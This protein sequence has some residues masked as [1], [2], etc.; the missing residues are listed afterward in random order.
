MLAQVNQTALEFSSLSEMHQ[1]SF[2]NLF[3][4]DISEI[5]MNKIENMVGN[6]SSSQ[7]SFSA[8]FTSECSY[9]C[10][11]AYMGKSLN[12]IMVVLYVLCFLFLL[13]FRSFEE[14]FGMEFR[15]TRFLMYP[16]FFK[17]C[18]LCLRIVHYN[19]CPWVA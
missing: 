8:T 15:A 2:V 12:Q 6:G 3:I 18:L 5:D 4:P 9:E 11:Y 13:R 10:T 14:G 1:F 17:T 16:T 7:I 19:S